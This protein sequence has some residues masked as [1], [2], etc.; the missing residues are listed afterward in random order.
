MESKGNDPK[1]VRSTRTYIE[2]VNKLAGI[3][4]IGD[5]TPS[6]V[7][8][9]VTALKAD[10][11]SARAVNAHLTAIKSF[12]RWLKR[13]GRISDYALET[14]TKQNEQADR[15]RIRRALTPEEAG[16]VIKAAETSPEAGGLAGPDRAM[17]Y[18]LAL[19]TGF[20]A[21][22]LATL[23]PDRFALDA[24]P[25]TVTVMAC[26]AKNRTEAV[27]P[28]AAG[29]ADQL[30]PWLKTKAPG[31][32]VFDGMTERTAEMLRVDL[33][34]A[35]I[36][37]ET[38]SGVA[39]FHALRAAYVTNLVAS[40]ASVKTCQTLARHS[41]PTLTIG[42]YAKVS[43][44]DIKGAVENLPDLTPSESSPEPLAMT[45]TDPVPTPI[46]ER[47]SHYFPTG[48]DGT[49]R[50]RSDAGVMM[51]SDFESPMDRNPLEMTGLDG[52]S[53]E[54]SAAGGNAPRRT[55]TYNPLI[56]SQLLCQLS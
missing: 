53:Q 13:D 25:P 34:A 24:D 18:T 4:R 45:G 51:D 15:R 44:H 28:I 39:D 33:E 41:T 43:L 20:R 9:A 21:D 2:R 31:R 54:M 36:A 52:A 10:N 5:L 30:R 23:T 48:E 22:E 38:A 47:L 56:K 17:L 37:Y 6:S 32:P 49:I 16:K 11:L 8:V 7:S 19:G 50:N 42:L 35:G 26:Y 3:E 46:S 55:R 1:H 29:L 27:Q 14:L 40:G 12:S